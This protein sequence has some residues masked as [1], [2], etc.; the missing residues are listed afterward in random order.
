VAVHPKDKRYKKYV[1]KTL[2]VPS[3]EGNITLKV[4]AD[5][6]VDPKFGTGVIKVTPGHDPTDFEIGKRHNLPV[7][8]VIGFDGK[9]TELAGKYAGLDRFETRKRIVED[10]K[11][12]GLIDR[13]EPYRHAVGVCYRCRTVVEPLIS[14]QWYVRMKPLAE[15]AIKAVKTGRIKIVPRGWSKTYY[16]WMEN[17]RDWAISRQ[18]WWGHRIPVWYCDKDGSMHVS[19]T[20]LTACP[21]CGGALRQDTDVLDTWFSSGLWPFSTLGWPESTPELKV[22]YPTSVLSTGFDILF[23]WVARMAMLGIKFM[24]DVPFRHVYIHAL[25]RDAEGQKMS[26]SKGNV[27]DPLH[28][29]DK[30]GTDAFRFTLAALAAQGRDIRLAEERIEGYR[31]FAN[32][33]WNA[34]RL[35]LTNLEG[36]DPALARRGTPSVADRWIKS[37]LTEATAQVRKAIDSY[38]FNDAASAVYQ[39][40]WHEYCDWYLE[41]AKRSL[42]QPESPAARAV[43]QRTL[44]ETLEATLR[45]LHPFMP[46]IS[47]ELW[48]RLPHQGESIVIAPFPKATRKGRDPEAE[49]LMAPI[50]DFVGAIRTIRSESRI[51]PAVELAVSVKPAGPEVA[52]AL[53]AGAA[54]I[55]SLARAAITVSADGARPANS[56]MAA[57]PSGDVFVRLEGVVDFEAERARLRKEVERA[58]KEIAFLEGKLGRAD[59]VE[60]APAL[61][62]ERERARLTEQRETEQKLA[63]SLAALG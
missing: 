47:E 55:G 3:V 25:I 37:R 34:A 5:E 29:M 6:A 45:L 12:L 40:L 28:V 22:F 8:S 27:V 53:A 18:L 32:K 44:V 19:R 31:N 1:G 35:V 42:Y 33:I 52:G 41:I 50:L 10:M 49:R 9:M 59:F 14:K 2:E 11:Q 13:I 58:R 26:K 46:F 38:R 21:Q 7:R 48:Q 30:Y 24:G 62:V 23:F 4:V 39:F 51:S 17:I 61:V 36:Y 20:D 15:P 63:A 16:H 60:R 57:T 43:T 54:V 56:A